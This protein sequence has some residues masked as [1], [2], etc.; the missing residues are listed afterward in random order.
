MFEH[1]KESHARDMA[2]DRLV[3]LHE[4]QSIVSTTSY[5]ES[6][7]CDEVVRT[8]ARDLQSMRA[9]WNGTPESLDRHLAEVARF[10]SHC[11]QNARGDAAASRCRVCNS[12]LQ[13]QGDSTWKES[14]LATEF[15]WNISVARFWCR[16]CSDRLEKVLLPLREGFDITG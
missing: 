15:D 12:R 13:P 10:L 2:Y 5:V 14:L 11:A 6:S 1:S 4:L 8:V 9:I 16:E 7:K 3:V